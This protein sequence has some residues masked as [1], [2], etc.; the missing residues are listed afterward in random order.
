MNFAGGFLKIGVLFFAVISSMFF[1]EAFQKISI[2]KP[3][4]A[5]SHD[6]TAVA[7]AY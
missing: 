1:K 2:L 6:V 7:A 5:L 4:S 3:P